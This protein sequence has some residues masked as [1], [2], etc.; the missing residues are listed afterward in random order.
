M[1]D[2]VQ[3]NVRVGEDVPTVR[4]QPRVEIINRISGFEFNIN[5]IIGAA[6]CPKGSGEQK[7]LEEAFNKLETEIQTDKFY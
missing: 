1:G 3:E 2:N 4:E 7:Y 5:H 6:R